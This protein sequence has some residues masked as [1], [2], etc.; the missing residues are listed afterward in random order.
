M[1]DIEN[2]LWS[3]ASYLNH[4]RS[5]HSSCSLKNYLYVFG[6][7]RNKTVE[8]LDTSV[9]IFP[10]TWEFISMEGYA[11]RDALVTAV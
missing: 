8:R 3:K 6:G 4:G 9:E 11:L 1:Y 2:D 10:Y 5:Y 7:D